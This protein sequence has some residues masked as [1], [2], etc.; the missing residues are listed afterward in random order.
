MTDIET[1]YLKDYGMV[2]NPVAI[3]FEHGRGHEK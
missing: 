2:L 3:C 1:M